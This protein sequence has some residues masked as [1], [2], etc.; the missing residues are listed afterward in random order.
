MASF[1]FRIVPLHRTARIAS[2]GFGL[3]AMGSSTNSTAL[4]DFAKEIIHLGARELSSICA[5]VR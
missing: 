5:T 3:R 1:T 2:F 4:K